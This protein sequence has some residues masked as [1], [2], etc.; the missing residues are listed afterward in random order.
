LCAARMVSVEPT[1]YLTHLV[2]TLVCSPHG[3]CGAHS[4]LDPPGWDPCVQPAWS[5]WGLLI[6]WPTWLGPLCAARMVSVEPTHYL[7]HLVGTLVCS[8]HGQCGA[9]SLLD[10]PGWDPCVQPAW[11]VWSPLITWPTWLGPLCAARMVSVEPTHYLTHLVGTVMCSPRGHQAGGILVK[12]THQ[13]PQP[14]ALHH[15]SS[16]I[17]IFPNYSKTSS[18]LF[19]NLLFLF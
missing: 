17:K 18:Y 6:T 9:H 12:H 10:P 11:S 5:V 19:L 7:T 14:A 1:H 2:G 3:Q 8:P 4:L 13:L 15:T 16:N